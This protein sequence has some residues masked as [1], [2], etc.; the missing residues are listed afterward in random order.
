[1]HWNNKTEA[2]NQLY[3]LKMTVEITIY[4]SKVILCQRKIVSIFKF[5]NKAQNFVMANK[6]IASL[7]V[8]KWFIFWMNLLR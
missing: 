7:K 4:D 2:H 3:I 5:L 8:N 1:M 6:W